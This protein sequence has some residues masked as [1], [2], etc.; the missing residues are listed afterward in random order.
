MKR[1]II[2]GIIAFIICGVIISALH[3]RNAD[4]NLYSDKQYKDNKEVSLNDEQTLEQESLTKMALEVKADMEEKGWKD[5]DYKEGLIYDSFRES[6]V[7][8]PSEEE[9]GLLIYS[10][11][12]HT[13]GMYDNPITAVVEIALNGERQEGEIYK[14]FYVSKAGRDSFVSAYDE[15]QS[16]SYFDEDEV[17]FADDK[18]LWDY[19]YSY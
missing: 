4:N 18:D 12:G 19:M 15:K 5:V 13:D 3:N 8:E 16:Y 17:V 14:I 11:W 7:I 10:V 1:K 2:I 9:K 6:V